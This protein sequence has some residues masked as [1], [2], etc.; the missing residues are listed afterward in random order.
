MEMKILALI[1]ARGGSKG[2]LNKNIRSFNGKPLIGY[3]VDCAKQS[4]YVDRVMVSTDDE[5][6]ARVGRECGAEV[7]FLRPA[8]MAGDKSPVMDAIIHHLNTLKETEGY[9]P[10][11]L[12][13][14]QTTSPLRRASD[15][16]TA[17][18]LFRSRDADSLVSCC[19]CENFLFTKDE[20]DRL[21]RVKNDVPMSTNRQMN[22][23]CYRL[24]GC[25]VY[26]IKTDVLLREKSFLAGKLVGY[27]IERWRAVDIDEPQDFVVGELLQ[28]QQDEIDRAIKSFS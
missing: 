5:E 18:E 28:R 27:E 26:L 25:M 17:V 2:V 20:E 6:I 19:F 10:T 22:T 9:E 21:S 8:E 11:H 7:P 23:K 4:K 24:D 3:S 13:L 15:I 12:L 16:D 1:P 14:L